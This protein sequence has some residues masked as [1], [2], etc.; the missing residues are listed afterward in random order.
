VLQR[1]VRGVEI[2]VARYFNGCDW[3]GSVEMN[4]EHKRLFPG[5]IGPNTPE[6]GTLMWYEQE[7]EPRLFQETLGKLKPWL[8]R[9][10]FRGDI[11]LNLIVN[12]TGAYPLEVTAR[13][14]YP[15]L[16]LQM[17]MHRSPWGEFLRALAR[18]HSFALECRAGYGVAI[19]L[20]VPPFPFVS[21]SFGLP[22]RPSQR[23]HFRASL[24][25]QELTRVH[26]ERASPASVVSDKPNDLLESDGY[27][28]HVTGRGRTIS[29]AR[30]QAYRLVVKLVLPQMYYRRDIGEEFARVGLK[31]LK[32]WRYL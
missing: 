12:E 2:G 24:T 5:D 30:R 25:S 13:F 32:Q 17:E 15:A 4:V 9:V 20:A 10:N 29:A 22:Y 16:Q 28:L 27:G 23:T 14:G 6:M 21:N 31:Q 1:R 3:V 18:G 26:L 8:Q 11:D 19:L 7:A